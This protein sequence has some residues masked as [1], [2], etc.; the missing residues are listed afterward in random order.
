[1]TFNRIH[2]L[3]RS[4][5]PFAARFI[6]RHPKKFA[7]LAQ[8]WSNYVGRYEKIAGLTS[9]EVRQVEAVF[10]ELEC[11]EPLF[12]E[13]NGLQGMGMHPLLLLSYS[14]VRLMQPE[15]V[16]E[17]GV[18]EGFSSR[19]ILLAMAHNGRG[20]LHSY[21]C[22][23][24]DV[25]LLPGGR[26]Q[27]DMMGERSTGWLVPDHRR[28]RWN[29]V[30]GDARVLL[31]HV[32]AEHTGVDMFIHDSLHSYDHMMFEFQTAWPCLRQ[33]GILFCDDIDYNP[34]FFDFAKEVQLPTIRLNDRVGAMRK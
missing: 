5:F 11:R 13:L 21:D 22:P 15:V 27:R 26:C 10:Y 14:T 3:T 19:F 20:T 31:P 17:T 16:V 33:G 7:P 32:M 8:Y 24:Q 18:M 34:A 12:Q 25:E 28:S 1:M 23:N 2:L 30:R 4:F 6:L 9:Q 29:L